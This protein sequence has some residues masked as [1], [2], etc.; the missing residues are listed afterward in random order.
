MEVGPPGSP[1]R[2]RSQTAAVS[3]RLRAGVGS[4][5]GK[6]PQPVDQVCNEKTNVSE[7]LLKHR[8]GKR[9][10]RNRG[11]SITPGQRRTTGAPSARRRPA[12]SPGGVRCEGG[13]ISLQALAG[14]RRTCRLDTDGQSK[15][16]TV[17]PWLREGGPRPAVTGRGRVP[18]RG[19]GTDRLVVVTKAL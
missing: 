18:M 17:A 3:C 12:C 19:T 2:R 7:P 10:H 9:W 1:C 6:G 11:L 8:N 13:V 15:W 14:N 5:C 4:D 16:V